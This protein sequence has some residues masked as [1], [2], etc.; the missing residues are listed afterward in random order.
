MTRP[1]VHTFLSCLAAQSPAARKTLLLTCRRH[2]D[3]LRVS[4]AICLSYC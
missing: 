4:S 3:L 2:V 1:A